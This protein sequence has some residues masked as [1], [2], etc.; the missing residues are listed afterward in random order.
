MTR[1]RTSVKT[2]KPP[3]MCNGVESMVSGRFDFDAG[4]AFQIMRAWQV[5]GR[6]GYQFL[7][8]SLIVRLHIPSLEFLQRIR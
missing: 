5:Q 3:A 2:V 4:V 8:F 7:A 1:A 6:L